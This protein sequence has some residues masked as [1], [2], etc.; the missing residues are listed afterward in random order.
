MKSSAY[1]TL[2]Q[3]IIKVD[4]SIRSA[5]ITNE[6]GII[7]HISHRKGMKPLLSSEERGQYAITAATRQFT[8]LRWEVLLGK[9]QYASSHYTKLIRATIPVTDDNRKLSFVIILSLDAGTDNFHEIILGKVIPLI[10]KGDL[11]RTPEG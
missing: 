4:S 2:C 11:T 3:E 7:L 9:I 10:K 5:G 6:D 8:R 1:K